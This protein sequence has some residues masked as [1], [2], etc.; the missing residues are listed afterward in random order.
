MGGW[1][2]SFRSGWPIFRCYVSF[3]KGTSPA[4][5]GL[6]FLLAAKKHPENFRSSQELM[7]GV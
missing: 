4:V 5:S 7:D 6:E 1:N 3:R 2:T